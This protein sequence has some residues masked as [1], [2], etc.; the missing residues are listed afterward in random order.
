MS[1]SIC[2][3]CLEIPDSD[4][5]RDTGRVLKQTE[6]LLGMGKA[7]VFQRPKSCFKYHPFPDPIGNPCFSGPSLSLLQTG[8][9]LSQADF[10][11]QVA[12]L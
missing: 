12:I 7:H 1:E 6:G 2:R 8:Q 10:S 9:G 4:L 5:L 3:T 11:L